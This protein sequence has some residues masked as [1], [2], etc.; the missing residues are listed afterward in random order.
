MESFL[1][2]A[3]IEMYSYDER[4]CGSSDILEDTCLWRPWC[5]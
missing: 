1:P 3:G 2:D 5:K 4:G